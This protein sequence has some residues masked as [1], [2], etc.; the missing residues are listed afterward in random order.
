MVLWLHFYVFFVFCF[1]FENEYTFSHRL[2]FFIFFKREIIILF[3]FV[4]ERITDAPL[5]PPPG[6]L[7][8]PAQVWMELHDV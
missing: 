2:Y 8:P 4:A 3:I 5:P 6:L 1:F 7:P